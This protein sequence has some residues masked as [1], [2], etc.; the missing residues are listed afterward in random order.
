MLGAEAQ[1]AAYQ[2]AANVS[3]ALDWAAANLAQVGRELCAA[4]D[5]ITSAQEQQL[6][7]QIGT[8]L[9][10]AYAVSTLNP[11]VGVPAAGAAIYGNML[12]AARRGGSTIEILRAGGVGPR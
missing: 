5:Q 1:L 6:R 11:A 10:L 9:A 3:A 4:C 8:R 7:T 2:N 12:S